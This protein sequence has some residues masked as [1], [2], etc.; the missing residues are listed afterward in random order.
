MFTEVRFYWSIGEDI[1]KAR[2][3]AKWG[4]KFYNQFS[5]DLQAQF[6][7]R[8]GFSVRNLQYISQMYRL[9]ASEQIITPQAVA[10]LPTADSEFTPQAVA[11]I[12]PIYCTAVDHLYK[13]DND[14]DT[15]GLLFCKEKN[16]LVAQW[17]V[18]KSEQPI[19]ITRYELEKLLPQSRQH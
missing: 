13:T 1:T 16:D 12:T 4:S 2:A 7:D 9:F 11:Q 8:K 19:A 14:K 10:Q 18:E 15:I 5:R 6:P 3:E 17:T